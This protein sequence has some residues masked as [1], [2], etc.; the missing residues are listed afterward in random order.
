MVCP[1]CHR[2]QDRYPAGFVHVAGDFFAGHRDEMLQLLRHHE[3]KEKA[4]HPMA[5]IIAIEDEGAGVLVT[6]TDIHLARDLGEALH[7]AYQGQLDYHYNEAQMLL[8]VY[9]ER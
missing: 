9:W 8:R 5:R 6:T 1:A 3:E 7:H 2:V 4:E